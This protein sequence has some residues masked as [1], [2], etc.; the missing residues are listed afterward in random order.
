MNHLIRPF[1]PDDTDAVIALWE[2]CG[3]TRPQNDPRKDI[4]R[5]L[6]VQPELFLVATDGALLMGTV[7]AGYD[8]H[9]GWIN[10]L[11]VDPEARRRG[12]GRE[13]MQRAEAELFKRGCP[14][15]NLQIRGSNTEALGFY[16]AI[17]F[18]EDDVVSMGKRLI[19]DDDADVRNP[20][21][22]KLATEP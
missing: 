9:R 22:G 4:E 21:S 18:L 13:I 2:N 15:I 5:K 10:Y 12:L 14:K 11:A 19:P 17:G 20:G 16:R 6:E 3:L 1:H 8:G 7:M